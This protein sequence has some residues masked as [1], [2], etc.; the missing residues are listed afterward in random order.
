M[1]INMNPN[2]ELNQSIVKVPNLV[3]VP[4][5][6]INQ[7]YQFQESMMMYT[8][9]I[10]EVKTKLEV[11]NDELSVRNSR[12]PIE[13]VKSRVKKPVSIVEK[14]T[15]RGLP[16]SLESMMENLDDV[17]G[18]RVICSFL[19]DIYAVADML[20]RQ[21]DVHIIAIK[22]YIRQP[23]SNG[24]R[25]YHMIVEIPVFFSDQKK[26][27]RVEV[28]IRTMA[29]DFWA[30]LDHQLKYKKEMQVYSQEISEEL[31]ECA[32]VIA[33]TDQKMLNIRKRIEE[34]GITVT[35]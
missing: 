34:Q 22:D 21:D 10:R 29:M 15:R 27:I 17:A 4:D 13:L 23:K 2:S 3:S 16:V 35:K 31:R 8:C 6:L 19:D 30:S 7:A 28:Q 18:I 1:N 26:W 12:N 25:S 20:A 32:D 9:A 11:L 14:L 5:P 24:Y 33:L